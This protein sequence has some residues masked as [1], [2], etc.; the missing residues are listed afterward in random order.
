VHITVAVAAV[1]LTAVACSGSDPEPSP[2]PTGTPASVTSVPSTPA[3]SPAP[4][5]TPAAPT[6]P[7]AARADTPAGAEAFARFYIVTQ[8]YANRTGD[9]KLL[10]SLGQCPGCIAVA[11][12]IEH[13]Y[14]SG[15]RVE[16][17]TL[18]VIA[19]TVTRHVAGEA[20]L[21]AVTYKQATGRQVNKDGSSQVVPAATNK[22]LQT[23][24]LMQNAG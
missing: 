7:A 20:A 23:L 21:V 10:R 16:G 1:A 11:D 4:T 8:D 18:T 3:T 9:T 22:V 2:V 15:G 14:Q 5:P 13:F 24:R 6:L 17:G 12:S 19:A